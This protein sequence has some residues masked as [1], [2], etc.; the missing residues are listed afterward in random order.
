MT[1]KQDKNI[2]WPEYINKNIK[3]S[4]GRKISKKYAIEKPN[5]TELYEV[6]KILNLSPIIELEKKYPKYYSENKG[7]III[8]KTLSYNKKKLLVILSEL[9]KKYRNKK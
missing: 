1:M 9:I 7:R 3:L 4:D 2:I 5:I 8:N 6:A